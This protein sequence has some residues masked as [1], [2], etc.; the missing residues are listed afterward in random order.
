M[1]SGRIM[2]GKRREEES[3]SNVLEIWRL[4]LQGTSFC[5]RPVEECI[6][7]LPRKG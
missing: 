5:V 1:W 7:I 4:I 6:R 2:S 3:K